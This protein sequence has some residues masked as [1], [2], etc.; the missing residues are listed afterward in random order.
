MFK[1]WT[2]KEAKDQIITTDM[3]SVARQ[4]TPLICHL[5]R[6]PEL[7][8]FA[9]T[10]IL[11]F[12]RKHREQARGHLRQYQLGRLECPIFFSPHKKTQIR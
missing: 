4:S 3:R 10:L 5:R 8:F 6:L 1:S 12:S 7:L 11:F 9:A 2:L